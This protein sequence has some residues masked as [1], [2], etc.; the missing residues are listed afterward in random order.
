MRRR[1]GATAPFALSR[2]GT[3][4]PPRSGEGGGGGGGGG[5]IGHTSV[6]SITDPSGHVWV[7]GGGSGGGGGGGGGGGAATRSGPKF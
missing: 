7:A 1:S 2:F 5:G 4:Q 3:V 6:A